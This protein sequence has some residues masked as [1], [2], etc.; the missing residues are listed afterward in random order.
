MMKLEQKHKSFSYWMYRI[1]RWL[2]WIFYPS[3]QVEGQDNLPNDACIIVGNHSQLNGPIVGQLYFPGNPRIWCAAQMMHIREVPEY[4]FEDFWRN[5]PKEIRWFYKVLSFVI[6]P[7]SACIFNNADTIAVY[8]DN[9]LVSTFKQTIRSL[10]SGTNVILFPEHREEYN[11]IVNR[12]QEHFIDVARLYYKRTGKKLSFV[13]LYIAPKLRKAYIGNPVVFQP[14]VPIEEERKR[15]C[16]YLMDAITDT[17]V[18]LP[19][20]IVV[21][22]TN[23]PKNAYPWNLTK[24]EFVNEIK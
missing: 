24:E 7:L 11:H 22:Y 10:E 12:F 15:I 14:S 9:R 2:V 5:K 17:A 8:R 3:I 13:P 18:K 1:I 4:A 16:R 20:H 23:M 21:P 19:R 6:A